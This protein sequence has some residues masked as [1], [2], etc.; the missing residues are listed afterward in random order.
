MAR[1]RPVVAVLM[2][3][4]SDWPAMKETV[5]LLNTLKVPCET[6][7]IS[8]HR[9]PEKAAE[10]ARRAEKAGFRVIIAAAGGAAHLAGVVASWTTLPVIGVPLQGWAFDGLDAL[11]STVQMPG[12]IPVA[13]VA[14]GKA[15]ASNA[16]L[17]AAEIL[18]LGDKGLNQR[19]KALR[20]ESA[21]AVAA[22]DKKI[23]ARAK[24]LAK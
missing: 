15:G 11:L 3:S 22:K 17:L 19:V 9:T 23:S 1:R 7:V 21:Q 13:T 24:R 20:K 8:A 4:D 10:F 12:G 16:A 14:V 18:A 5:A 2:G 6:R